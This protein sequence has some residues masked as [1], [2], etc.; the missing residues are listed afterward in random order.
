[1]EPH[2]E[3]SG[4]LY[5]TKI[6]ITH[7]IYQENYQ[8]RVIPRGSKLGRKEDKMRVILAMIG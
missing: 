2:I 3:V 4:W 7:I 8:S 6:H 5:Q 1:M